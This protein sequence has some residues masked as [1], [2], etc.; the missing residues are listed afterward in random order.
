MMADDEVYMGKNYRLCCGGCEG[1]LKHFS[2]SIYLCKMCQRVIYLPKEELQRLKSE[3]QHIRREQRKECSVHFSEKKNKKNPIFISYTPL[4]L[5]HPEICYFNECAI[6][7]NTID[8]AISAITAT[9]MATIMIAR[10]MKII[11]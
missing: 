8:K 4:F 3:K 9:T 6:G 10:M 5:E 2:G 11:R 1:Y 7:P